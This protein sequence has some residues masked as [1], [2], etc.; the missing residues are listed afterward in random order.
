MNPKVGRVNIP[1]FAIVA[2]IPGAVRAAHAERLQNREAESAGGSKV[3]A[4]EVAEEVL[5]FVA[6]LGEAVLPAVLKANGVT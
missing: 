2:A 3:T 4:G 6:A 5:A 1:V